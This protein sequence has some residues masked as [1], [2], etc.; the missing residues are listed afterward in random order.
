MK[1]LIEMVKKV[2]K[3]KP[4]IIEEEKEEYKPSEK[5]IEK[6]EEKQNIKIKNIN[7]DLIKKINTYD[8]IIVKML[9]DEIIEND[10]EES[11][12]IRPFIVEE[13]DDSKEVLKG[14]YLTS[15]IK[16]G[17]FYKQKYSGFRLILRKENYKLNKTSVV[18]INDKID[19]PY[20]NINKIIDSIKK[21]DLKKLKKYIELVDGKIVVSNKENL[22]IEIGDIIKYNEMEYIIFQIDNSNCYAYNIIKTD[23]YID[24]RDNHQ[25]TRFDK[26]IYYVEYK[27]NITLNKFEDIE[28]ID[29]FDECVVER[30]RENKKLLKLEKRKVKRKTKKRS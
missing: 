21:E 10:I 14:H 9:D 29:R 4:K 22:V 13:K 19:I 11:H 20:E 17:L 27:N 16:S 12:Q 18:I 24:V 25:Y 2:L 7:W 8:I 5:I 23:E 28:I 1:K 30:I 3:I 26:Q 15:N 6:I